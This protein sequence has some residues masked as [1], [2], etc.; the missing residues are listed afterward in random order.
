MGE[1]EHTSKGM[2]EERDEEG[3]M[4]CLPVVKTH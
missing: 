4:A 3:G 1:V 2:E